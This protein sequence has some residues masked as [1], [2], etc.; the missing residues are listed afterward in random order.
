MA[1]ITNDD[2]NALCADIDL[3]R[4]VFKHDNRDKLLARAEILIRRAREQLKE[5]LAER[6]GV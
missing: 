1:K 5:L 4:G 6:A 3:W 2:I